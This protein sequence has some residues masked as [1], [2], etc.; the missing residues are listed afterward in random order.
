M[1]SAESNIGAA[2]ARMAMFFL[3]AALS[4]SNMR[5]SARVRHRGRAREAERSPSLT[6]FTSYRTT[7]LRERNRVAG[8][9]VF[10]Q[11][12]Q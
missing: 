6:G 7:P 10:R 3:L 5:C 12:N 4:I 9:T 8:E 2:G 11:T 1:P